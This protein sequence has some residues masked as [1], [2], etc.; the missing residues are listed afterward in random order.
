MTDTPEP[1]LPQ[2]A[3]YGVVVG[4]GVVFAVGESTSHVLRGS[5]TKKVPLADQRPQA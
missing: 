5:T 4:F 1:H 2:G 3:G